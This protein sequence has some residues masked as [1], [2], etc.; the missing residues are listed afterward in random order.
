MQSI[1]KLNREHNTIR[2]SQ[3]SKIFDQKKNLTLI[4]GG[5]GVSILDTDVNFFSMEKKNPTANIT[6]NSEKQNAFMF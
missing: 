4:H 3:S 6:L 5:R 2:S 1:I